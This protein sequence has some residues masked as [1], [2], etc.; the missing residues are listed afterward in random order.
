MRP[1]IVLL[2]ALTALA[3]WHLTG[4]RPQRDIFIQ[5]RLTLASAEPVEGAQVDVILVFPE[6]KLKITPQGR[7]LVALRT[8]GAGA[9]WLTR[10]DW[11]SAWRRIN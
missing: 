1:L 5:G 3:A 2:N 10:P 11:A 6:T 4:L 9:I 7:Q 8:L